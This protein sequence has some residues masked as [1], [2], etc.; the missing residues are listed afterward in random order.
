M[1]ITFELIEKLKKNQF[2]HYPVMVHYPVMDGSGPQASPLPLHHHP[3]CMKKYHLIP[4]GR[5][6]Y[7]PPQALRHG[8]VCRG[9]ELCRRLN[10][11]EVL[12][13]IQRLRNIEGGVFAVGGE[14]SNVVPH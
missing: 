1:V 7:Q 10:N 12:Y 11:V 3:V 5:P 2:M 13:N 4:H 6:A 14:V 9:W 8:R